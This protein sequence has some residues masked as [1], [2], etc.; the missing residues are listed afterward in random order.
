MIPNRMVI[1]TKDAINITGRSERSCQ[2]LMSNIRKHLKKKKRAVITV[3]E[4]CNYTNLNKDD[5][6][7]YLL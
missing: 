1:Y 4:F 2:R 7:K 3:D 5:I 6:K